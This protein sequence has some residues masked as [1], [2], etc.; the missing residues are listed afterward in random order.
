V[1]ARDAHDKLADAVIDGRTTGASTRLGPLTTHE[2][3][4]PAQKRLWRH[5]QA[6]SALLRQDSRQ[7]GKEG[8][9]GR[10]QGRRPPL[11]P[12]EYDQLMS[13]N[14]QLDV[15]GELTAP[16]ADQQ[17]QHSREGE[18]GERKGACT[19]APIARY[20]AQ[21]ERD[22]RS[23]ISYRVAKPAANLV[24]RARVNL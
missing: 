23:T 16:A 8:A 4:V 2:L 11:L 5:D 22:R 1:G 9:I 18:I 7:R 3:P 20:E 24:S 15:F 17:P 12:P 14:E 10:A 13:Q 21:Q 6:A 19:D